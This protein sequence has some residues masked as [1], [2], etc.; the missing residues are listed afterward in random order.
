LSDSSLDKDLDF[1]EPVENKGRQNSLKKPDI[2][3]SEKGD[4]TSSGKISTKSKPTPNPIKFSE[5]I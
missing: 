4:Q 1:G 3:P 2:V 5:R